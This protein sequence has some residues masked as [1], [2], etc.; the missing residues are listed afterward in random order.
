MPL[1]RLHRWGSTAVGLSEQDPHYFLN[2]HQVWTIALQQEEGSTPA[3]QQTSGWKTELRK[4]QLS[5]IWLQSMN[6]RLCSGSQG[7]NYEGQ[8]GWTCCLKARTSHIWILHSRLRKGTSRGLKM[9]MVPWEGFSRL[10]IKGNRQN[11]TVNKPNWYFLKKKPESCKASRSKKFIFAYILGHTPPPMSA[12]R[13]F[14]GQR[15]VLPLM[16]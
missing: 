11:K 2:K 9:E 7:M 12:G 16:E 10:K 8:T 1:V 5:S 6:G 13:F 3:A 14:G 15:K 4:G